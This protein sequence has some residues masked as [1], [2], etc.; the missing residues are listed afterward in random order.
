MDDLGTPKLKEGS[1]TDWD[2]NPSILAL[3]MAWKEG[4]KSQII[5]KKLFHLKKKFCHYLFF[6]H[7]VVA[8]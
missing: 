8:N 4:F 1:T 7:Y 2:K 6:Y 5:I 3:Q